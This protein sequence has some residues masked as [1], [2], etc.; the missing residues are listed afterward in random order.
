MESLCELYGVRHVKVLPYQPSSNGA[1]EAAVKKVSGALQRHC[2]A[3]RD[4]DRYLQLLTHALN[5]SI[6]ERTGKSAFDGGS[7]AARWHMRF[8]L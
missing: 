2:N 8:A 3:L 5:W 1:V 6:I 7:M 4:W